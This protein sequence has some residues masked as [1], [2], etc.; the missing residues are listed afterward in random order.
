[1]SDRGCFYFT[2]FF[3]YTEFFF[4]AS[5][6]YFEPENLPIRSKFKLKLEAPLATTTTTTTTT[7]KQKPSNT[8][9]KKNKTQ[10]WCELD[11]AST[12]RRLKTAASRRRKTIGRR[13]ETTAGARVVVPHQRN[14]KRHQKSSRTMLVCFR[15][16]CLHWRR[17]IKVGFPRFPGGKTNLIFSF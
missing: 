15:A 1:M 7:Q 14:A 9:T 13:F 16:W 5:C 10:N 4:L 6:C 3:F 12:G 8:H 11:A 2:C 17:P